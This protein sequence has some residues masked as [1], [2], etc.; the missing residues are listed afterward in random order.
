M[1]VLIV[2]A[3]GLRLE[4]IAAAIKRSFVLTRIFG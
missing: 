1:M 2:A 3:I 4:T